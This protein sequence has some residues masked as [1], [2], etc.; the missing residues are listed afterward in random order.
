MTGAIVAEFVGSQA[1]L[2]Y[3]LLRASSNL[4]TALIFGVVVVLSVMGLLFAYVVEFIEW[5][6][7]PW[8]RKES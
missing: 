2:G 8:Q 1:G 5:L 6:V 4:D 3:L 7:M